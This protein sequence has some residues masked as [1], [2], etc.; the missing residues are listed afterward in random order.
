MTLERH[1]LYLLFILSLALS[2]YSSDAWA[3]ED[4]TRIQNL[5]SSLNSYAQEYPAINEEVN[6]NLS[7]TSL[8]NF[9]LAVAK[10][11]DINFHLSPA[12]ENI[13]IVNNF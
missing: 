7:N 10:V 12:L 13:T 5:E 8:S 6:I 9:L 2:C 11:H 1:T 4:A 3:Q